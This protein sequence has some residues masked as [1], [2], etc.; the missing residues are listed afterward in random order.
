MPENTPSHVAEV[1]DEIELSQLLSGY[2][3]KPAV[4]SECQ[5][6]EGKNT[7]SD[8]VNGVLGELG[9]KTALSNPEEYLD[10][11][12]VPVYESI[13]NIYQHCEGIGDFRFYFSDDRQKLLG[14]FELNDTT[15][16][17]TPGLQDYRQ[18]LKA[19]RNQQVSDDYGNLLMKFMEDEGSDDVQDIE[20][21]HLGTTMML[22]AK[23]MLRL[24]IANIS[25]QAYFFFESRLGSRK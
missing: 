16:F 6:S 5:P 23:D 21:L 4:E 19:A 13:Q 24:G 10:S 9:Q 15:Q 14:L 2:Q 7:I 3:K 11:I 22:R 12:L 1:V 25:G 17:G 20:E 18:V 8:A